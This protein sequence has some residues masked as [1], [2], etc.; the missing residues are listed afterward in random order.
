M[1]LNPAIG[2]ASA[3]VEALSYIQRFHNKIVVVKVGGSIMDDEQALSNLLND[4]VF[5]NYVGMQ[6]VLVHGGGKA[7]NQAMETAGLKPQM[8][9]GR[10]YTDE[11]TLAIA[12]H[13]LCNQ[14]NRF[15]VNFIQTQGCEAMGLHSL[16]SNVLFAEKTYLQGPDGRRIDLGMVGDVT[17]VNARLLQLLVQADSIPCIATI[18][19][20][21]AGNRLN[22]N[23]DTAA[24]AVAAALKAEKLVVVS[25]THGIRSDPND[26]ESLVHSVTVTQVDQMVKDGIITSG[27]LPK[28]EA[29]VAALRGGVTKTHIIDG[30]IPHSLL[31]EIYTEA[32]IGT[33][34]VL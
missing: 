1:E 22:V 2:K 14:V 34:I 28:V 25:D 19:R 24:G 12:E 8:V 13:V 18:A 32:G 23:A 21:T 10:R 29:C 16:S 15:I 9:Q 27:M 3:L 31:L 33:E 30:R 6:P 4:I 11:R 7:I 17:S 5:M 20:D 26:P